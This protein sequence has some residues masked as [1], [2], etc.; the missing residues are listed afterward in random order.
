LVGFVINR[1]SIPNYSIRGT[2][3][4]SDRQENQ[5]GVVL[6]NLNG[7]LNTGEAIENVLSVLKS[8]RITENTIDKIDFGIKYYT[9]G[10]IQKFVEIYKNN[11]IKV[12]FDSTHLQEL[13]GSFKVKIVD[14]NSFI[15]E[16]VTNGKLFYP[17]TQTEEL[18]RNI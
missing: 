12:V 17:S 13:N 6:L 3:V 1:Y 15:L 9:V 7:M 16:K 8:R 18:N 4:I 10:K 2:V 11:P 14:Q 5:Q